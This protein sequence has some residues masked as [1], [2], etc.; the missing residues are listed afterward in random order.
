MGAW[1]HIGTPGSTP[2]VTFPSLK[3]SGKS[4]FSWE[5]GKGQVGHVGSWAP[6]WFPGW[7]LQSLNSQPGETGVL[8]PCLPSA[9]TLQ[10]G[11][12]RSAWVSW[13]FL[14]GHL[15]LSCLLLLSSVPSLTTACVGQQDFPRGEEDRGLEVTWPAQGRWWRSQDSSS[16]FALPPGE[17]RAGS[18]PSSPK[19]ERKYPDR[20]GLAGQAPSHQKRTP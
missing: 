1:V 9:P 19:G 18:Q 5:G 17:L 13:S 4:S 7:M 12:M 16:I 6:Q 15:G 2:C 20:V 3:P 11:R 8:A 10:V 14:S